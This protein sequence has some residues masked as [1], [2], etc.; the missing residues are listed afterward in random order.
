MV[1]DI[2][3]IQNELPHRYPFLLIDR[4]V[5]IVPNQSIHAIKNVTCNEIY[6]QGH[7]PNHMVMPG[8]L[9]I[10]SMAQA[11]GILFRRHSDVSWIDGSYCY[12]A[13]VDQARFRQVVYPG[14]QAH[15]HAE[16]KRV[17]KRLG[18]FE[19]KVRVEDHIACSAVILLGLPEIDHHK[20]LSHGQSN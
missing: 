11:C 19:C 9:L 2:H 18:Q 10:E 14:H 1:M 13:G 8:V 15:I 7:F 4:V 12:L 20:E 17:R 6:F 16:V 5:N 3:A